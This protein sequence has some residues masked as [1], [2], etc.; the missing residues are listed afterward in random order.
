[1]IVLWKKC[2]NSMTIQQILRK[3]LTYGVKY[4]L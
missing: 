1:M 2:I 3:S 4:R